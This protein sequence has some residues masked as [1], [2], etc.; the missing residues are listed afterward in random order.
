MVRKL[1]NLRVKKKAKQKSSY[2]KLV[3]IFFLHLE[4]LMSK[5][6]QNTQIFDFLQK[7]KHLN[8]LPSS[9]DV[10]EAFE[11]FSKVIPRSVGDITK[12]RSFDVVKESQKPLEFEV[13]QPNVMVEMEQEQ[14]EEEE[15]YNT[16]LIPRPPC[17]KEDSNDEVVPSVKVIKV[18]NLKTW[19]HEETKY[20]L[21]LAPLTKPTIHWF[22]V[23][24]AF[25]K[26]YAEKPRSLTSLKQKRKSLVDKEKAKNPSLFEIGTNKVKKE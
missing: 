6:S 8:R 16:F 26:K 17:N 10:R 1:I 13:P 12:V 15:D 23:H 19:T 14:E 11:D 2:S 7:I 24:E 21:G 9:G 18:D 22:Q 4:K 20:L 3:S 5:P 25:N